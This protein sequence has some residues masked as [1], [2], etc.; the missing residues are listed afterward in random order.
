MTMQYAALD[1]AQPT[2]SVWRAGVL[3]AGVA[4]AVNAALYLAAVALGVFPRATVVPAAG[5]SVAL[6]PVVLMSALGALG[7]VGVFVLLR[8]ISRNAMRT[9]LATAG[10]VLALSLG[11]PLTVPGFTAAQVAVL[12]GMHVVVAAC[13][14]W[15]LSRWWG[16]AR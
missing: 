11:G 13:T 12:V 14:V 15:A 1:Q 9:F 7:G 3:A 10:V 5:E 8:T 4:A 2:A 16:T 6:V